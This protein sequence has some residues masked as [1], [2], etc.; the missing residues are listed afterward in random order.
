MFY[1]SRDITNKNL[2]VLTKSPY[3]SENIHNVSVLH[4]HKGGIGRKSLHFQMSKLE[5][6]KSDKG[7]ALNS[8]LLLQMGWGVEGGGWR[9]C[10]CP[11]KLFY[12]L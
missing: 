7:G 4:Q 6:T 2:T 3:M 10:K 8:R 5:T 11:L 1:V 12:G 9:K